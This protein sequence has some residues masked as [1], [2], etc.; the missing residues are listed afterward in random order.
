MTTAA[1]QVRCASDPLL[2]DAKWRARRKR[3]F[4]TVLLAVAVGPLV[5]GSALA[6]RSPDAQNP[7][8]VVSRHANSA[9]HARPPAL[10]PPSPAIL[11][12]Q[13]NSGCSVKP[14]RDSLSVPQT[15]VQ[16]CFVSPA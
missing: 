6:A 10:H 2:A 3:L 8:N 1:S 7:R 9:S 4:T 12:L 16:I 11:G 15:L 14:F 13:A 5:V